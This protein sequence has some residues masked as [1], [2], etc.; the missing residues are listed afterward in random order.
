MALNPSILFQQDTGPVFGPGLNALAQGRQQRMTLADMAKQAKIRDMAMAEAQQEADRKRTLRGLFGVNMEDGPEGPRLNEQRFL[1]DLARLGMGDTAFEY[2]NQFAANRAAAAEAQRKAQMEQAE[3]GLKERGADRA[4]KELGFKI[5]DL[6]QRRK[7]ASNNILRQLAGEAANRQLSE[8]KLQETIRSNRANE[9]IARNRPRADDKWQ[10][11]QTD[12]GIFQL[13][14]VTGEKRATGLKP[15]A[16]LN[17]KARENALNKKNTLSLARQQIADIK[18]KFKQLGPG[19][20]PLG[21]A[22]VPTEANKQ[23]DAAVDAFR[24]TARQLTRTPGEGAMS[25]F[26]TRLAQAQLPGRNEFRS[27]TEQ[28][29]AQMEDL[30]N[31]LDTG[32]SDMLQEAGMETK[33]G[34]GATGKWDK[35]ADPLGLGLGRGGQDDDPLGLGL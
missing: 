10:V 6:G 12:E 25:D 24:Q 35:D 27:V 23:F 4:D 16:K 22:G 9:D 13:N 33:A 7:Q 21:S 3:F 14:P 19:L 34:S 1:S 30:V 31:L 5:E 18:A 17:A 29:I 20:G 11:V 28:K 32:Y 26:E 8:R 15:P 2:G